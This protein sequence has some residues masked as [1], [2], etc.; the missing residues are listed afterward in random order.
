MVETAGAGPECV[1]HPTVREEDL[2]EGNGNTEAC[3]CALFQRSKWLGTSK[4]LCS[5]FCLLDL[6]PVCLPLQQQRLT[7]LFSQTLLQTQKVSLFSVQRCQMKLFHAIDGCRL[8]TS[9]F[10][11]RYHQCQKPGRGIG[12]KLLQSLCKL[13]PL[14]AFPEHTAAEGNKSQQLRVNNRIKMQVGETDILKTSPVIPVELLSAAWL[15]QDSKL[16]CLKNHS[17]KQ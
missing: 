3:L 2:R 7:K 4:P 9:M 10:A 15:K 17:R 11:E 1:S 5:V 13:N 6:A 14:P 16:T 12:S 8:E